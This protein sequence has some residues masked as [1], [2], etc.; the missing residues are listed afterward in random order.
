MKRKLAYLAVTGFALAAATAA[1]AEYPER[2]IKLIVPWAAGGD[3][4]NIFRPFAPN[5]EKHL[6]GTVV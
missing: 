1:H 6:G 3:T 2:P 5:L 4:D